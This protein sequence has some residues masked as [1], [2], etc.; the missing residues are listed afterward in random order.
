MNSDRARLFYSGVER[1]RLSFRDGVGDSAERAPE[2]DA[3]EIAGRHE[4]EFRAPE[5]LSAERGDR[6]VRVRLRRDDDRVEGRS[7]RV[8]RLAGNEA[9]GREGLRAVEIAQKDA[10]ARADRVEMRRGRRRRLEERY[11]AARP[12]EPGRVRAPDVPCSDDAYFH[13]RAPFRVCRREAGF[14]G[15]AVPE[16]ARKRP[17][18]LRIK[19]TLK[20]AAPSSARIKISEFRPGSAPSLPSASERLKSRPRRASKEKPAPCHITGKQVKLNGARFLK[21]PTRSSARV[22]EHLRVD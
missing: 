15:A 19:F 14:A 21:A 10:A 8:A 4:D 17:R 16:T 18:F 5:I 13:V 2:I 6:L 1:G 7:E 3:S 9:Q 22:R 12:G 11:A 20:R